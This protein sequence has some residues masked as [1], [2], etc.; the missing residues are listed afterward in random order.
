M[1]GSLGLTDEVNISSA[2]PE[3]V[4]AGEEHLTKVLRVLHELEATHLVGVIYGPMKKHLHPVTDQERRNGQQALSRLQVSAERLGI[5]LALEVVNRY[6][7]NIL[8]TARQAVEYVRAVGTDNLG[9]H[10]DT[11]H[12]N[13]EES[14]MFEP[15][16][17]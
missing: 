3:V 11:Y 10:L 17:G 13:I 7:S 5:T 16:I 9:V 12:M 1:T 6:E 15:V 14:G 8:N 2:D 4:R